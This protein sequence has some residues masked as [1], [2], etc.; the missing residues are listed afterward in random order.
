MAVLCPNAEQCGCLFGVS[1]FG[2]CHNSVCV[3]NLQQA[4]VEIL[5][6]IILTLFAPLPHTCMHTHTHADQ[7][8]AEPSPSSIAAFNLLRMG[9]LFSNQ[10]FKEKAKRIFTSSK[11]MLE[12]HSVALCQMCVAYLDYLNPPTEVNSG[13][14]PHHT[15]PVIRLYSGLHVMRMLATVA[16]EL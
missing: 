16:V 3:S 14:C 13:V 11:K 12:E 2:P 5:T 15:T 1:W 9:T 8:G 7:D 6:V 10:E 4:V